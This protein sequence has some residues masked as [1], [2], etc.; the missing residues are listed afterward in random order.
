[1]I[2]SI[3]TKLFVAIFFACLLTIGGLAA[4]VQFNFK[5][6]FLDY[7]NEQENRS[8]TQLGAQLLDLYEAK[9]NWQEL[10]NNPR[11]WN[12]LLHSAVRSSLFPA[13]GDDAERPPPPPPPPHE[14]EM[15]GLP[16]PRAH[17]AQRIERFSGRIVLL[18]ANRNPIKGTLR[19]E[20]PENLHELVSNGKIIG[21]LGMHR[22][23]RLTEKV[24]VEFADRLQYSL[25]LIGLLALPV[26]GILA[27]LLARHLSTP[28]QTLRNGTRQLTDGNYQLRMKPQGRD[29]LALLTRDFN[30]LAERLQQNE[31][32]RKQ[33][34]ADIAHE[35]RTPLAILRGE[36]EALQDGI[37][38]PDAST[39]ASLHQEVSHLQRLVSDLYDLSMS[40]SGALSYR[41]ERLDI[42][43]LLRETLTLHSTQLQ[44]QNLQTDTLGISQTPVWIQGDPQRLQQ[45]F[46]NLLEN[47]LRYTDKPGQ[48]RIS[49][50]L[51][52]TGIAILFNDSPPGVP[53][54]ALPH[55]F[56]RLFRVEASRNRA[57]GGAGIGL[58]ICRNIVAAHDGSI[59]ATHS[60]LGGL[61]IR[62]HF[63]L[64]QGKTA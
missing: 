41:K 63:P 6:S 43:A 2:V 20:V 62:L 5:R 17:F 47:S 37:N 16:S 25:W 59:S 11:L 12:T 45:L 13:N 26:T 55:L 46:K 64:E 24:D 1:M 39:F 48:L 44:E 29:E 38:Q 49:T 4:L 33:W 22:R 57:T 15:G 9:G 53:D 54:E 7:L 8:L 32:S 18:D 60:S 30:Q 10:E 40:D 52:T 27:F 3:R 58:S 50:S 35:L 56:E 23:Q 61:E 31:A 34:I 19:P 51:T 28:I 42:I 36:I 21:Y 14:R